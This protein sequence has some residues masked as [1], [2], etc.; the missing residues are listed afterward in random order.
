MKNSGISSPLPLPAEVFAHHRPLIER[1][2]TQWKAQGRAHPVLLL[3]GPAG[4]GKRE[5]AYTIAQWA[6]CAELAAPCQRCIACQKALHGTWTQFLEIHKN[7]SGH[8]QIDQFRKVRSLASLSLPEKE[9]QIVMIPDL[10]AM[11]PAT[12]NALL[13]LLEEPPRGW[14]FLLT[15]QDPSHI[16]P[17]LSSRCQRIQLTPLPEDRLISMLRSS[18]PALPDRQLPALVNLA[19]GNWRKAL[20]RSSK[21]QNEFWEKRNLFFKFLTRPR[22]QLEAVLQWASSSDASLDDFLEQAELILR[23]WI[24]WSL[25]P[26]QYVWKNSDHSETLSSLASAQL[27]SGFSPERL[28]SHWMGHSEKIWQARLHRTLPINKKILAYDLLLPWIG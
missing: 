2:V 16:L 5:L 1:W 28:R 18:S 22:D 13:K 12:A 4:I 27:K 26:T 14:V 6:L 19:Q 8:Y 7:E 3:T 25:N 24:G 23:D 9:T 17:T 11:N 10:E 20:E 15:A 21:D